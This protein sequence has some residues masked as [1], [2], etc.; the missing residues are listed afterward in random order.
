MKVARIFTVTVGCVLGLFSSR[1]SAQPFA[2]IAAV[3]GWTCNSGCGS[4]GVHVV[5]T[6][7]GA[8]LKTF[9]PA[10]LNDETDRLALSPDGR[11]IYAMIARRE[12]PTT[13]GPPARYQPRAIVP[14][15]L[16]AERVRPAVRLGTAEGSL[17]AAMAPD[18]R[19]LYVATEGPGVLSVLDTATDTIVQTLT[20]GGALR[21][22]AINP[23]G[24]RLY[25]LDT[26]GS[27]RVVDTQSVSLTAT[28]SAGPNPVSIAVGPDGSILV[29][30][31]TERTLTILSEADGGVVRTIS[32]AAPAT[33][34]ILN[35]AGTTAFVLQS[36]STAGG[37]I[38]T[39]TLATGASISLALPDRG[40]GLAVSADGARLFVL[41][42]RGR[43]RPEIVTVDGITGG[44]VTT[45]AL[46]ETTT[47]SLPF[48]YGT[49][50]AVVPPATCSVAV[51]PQTVIFGKAGGSKMLA[52]PVPGGCPWSVETG[53]TGVVVS[54][55]TGYGPVTLTVSIGPDIS[56][57]VTAVRINGQSLRVIRAVPKMVIDTPGQGEALIQP[58]RVAGWAVDDIGF[59]PLGNDKGT[60]VNTVH[61]WAFP[62]EGGPAR[63]VGAA[64]RYP[65]Y[66][67]TRFD[68]SLSLGGT[69]S[70]DSP[71]SSSGFELPVSDLAPGRWRLS[72]YAFSTRS[73]AFNNVATVEVT[74]EPRVSRPAMV[75]DSPRDGD[76]VAQSFPVSGW[77]IDRGALS[78]TG[79]DVVHVWAYPD[80]GAAPVFVGAATYSLRRPDVAAFFGNTQF[81][82]SGFALAAQGVVPG[83]YTLVA[84]ARSTLTGQF[85]IVQTVRLTV[86]GGAALRPRPR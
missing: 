41:N 68:V 77:A 57:R 9:F 80:G 84:F 70:L 23:A 40:D 69:A 48:L 44:L 32:L 62:L 74:I 78:G 60:G 22:M 10:G 58:F 4:T 1:V 24:T 56:G 79:V 43:R 66:G 52:A 53:T 42:A 16:T 67:A 21:A 27:I 26:S 19:R 28:Y 82:P 29:A 25:L 63:F 17:T 54:P 72:A 47:S 38:E 61:L 76:R 86:E 75:V 39:I 73:N 3:S 18:G 81:D 12:P 8:K 83:K 71:Y 64:D 34:A 14:I 46:E 33:Q 13:A 11:K 49:G 36:S 37:H 50:F 55:S 65:L 7:T 35:P 2:Y 31:G 20:V 85:N 59:E 5:N 45:T 51:A 15:D 6:A 30:D